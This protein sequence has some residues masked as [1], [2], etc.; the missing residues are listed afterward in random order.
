M[1]NEAG[2]NLLP[3]WLVSHS[4]VSPGLVET[5][6]ISKTERQVLVPKEQEV[7]SFCFFTNPTLLGLLEQR[8]SLAEVCSPREHTEAQVN[9]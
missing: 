7:A 3:N 2:S 6:K 8:E 4:G 5:C 9:W 1:L